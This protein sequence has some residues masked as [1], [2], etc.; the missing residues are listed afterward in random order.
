M[1]DINLTTLARTVAADSGLHDPREIADKMLAGMSAK[2]MAA[3]LRATLPGYVRDVIGS[4]QRQ[5]MR[6]AFRPNRSAKVQGIRDWWAEMLASSVFVNGEWKSFGDCTR[7]DVGWLAEQRRA[8]AARNLAQA[9]VYDE[10]E[11]LMAEHGVDTL[12]G[13]PRDVV[14]ASLSEVTA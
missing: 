12:A 7:S 1:Q 3:A 10:V 5:A 14:P 4:Q 11:R 6:Q 2:E 13:L 8:E 9:A